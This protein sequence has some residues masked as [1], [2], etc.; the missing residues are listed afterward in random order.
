LAGELLAVKR[1]D[2][3]AVAHALVGIDQRLPGAAVPHDHVAG[4]VLARGN[5]ALEATVLDRMVLHVHRQSLVRRIEAWPLRHR[6]TEQDAVVLQSEVV[7]ESAG[8]VLLDDECRP[9][10]P[11]GPGL[12]RLAWRHPWL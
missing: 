7:V 3:L 10:R 11:G 8:P 1:E 6:P 4:T 2:Q 5:R 9:L 12:A